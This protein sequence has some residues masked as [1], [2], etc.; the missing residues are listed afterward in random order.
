MCVAT[1]MDGEC[2]TIEPVE[3]F[4][5]ISSGALVATAMFDVALTVLENVV[6]T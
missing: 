6:T 3:L 5:S 2:L 4:T 1:E